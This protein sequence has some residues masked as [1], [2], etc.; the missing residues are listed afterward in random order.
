MLPGKFMKN[1][2]NFMH[3]SMAKG[4]SWAEVM[5]NHKKNQASRLAIVKLR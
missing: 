1:A 2:Y 4:T 5:L 3:S